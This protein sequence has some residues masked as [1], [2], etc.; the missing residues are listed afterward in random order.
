MKDDFIEKLP[1]IYGVYTGGFVVFIAL[2]AL[3]EYLGVNAQAIGILF[4]IFTVAVYAAIGVISR[5]KKVD[6]YYVAGREVP[7]VF[8]GMA[9]AADWMSGAIFIGLAGGLYFGGFAHLGF[10]IGWMGGYVLVNALMAPYLRKFGCYTLP[11]FVG[12]R[13]TGDFTRFLA[14]AIL[15]VVSFTYLTAQISATGAIASRMFQIPF[16]LAVWFGLVGI[17]FCSVLGGM[18]AVTWTQVAQYLVL[19]VAYLL[20]VIWISQS[21]GYGLLPH[22]S[23]GEAVQRVAELE[24]TLGLAGERTVTEDGLEALALAQNDPGAAG[25]MASWQFLTLAICMMAGTAS[26][27]HLLMR[28]FT[29][30]NVKAARQSVG[31]S[32]LFILVLFVSAPVLAT[33]AK[34]QLLDPEAATAVVGK[35]IDDVLSLG[36]VQTWSEFNFLRVEDLNG[37]GLV[38]AAEFFMHPDMVVLAAPEVAGLPYVVAGLIAAGGLAA[39]LSTADALL[40]SIANSASHDVYYK[41]TNPKADARARLWVARVALVVIGVVAA[42]FAKLQVGTALE[43]VAWAFCFACSGLFVPLLLGI[44]WKRANQQG[45][46]AGM[47]LGFAAGALYLYMVYDPPGEAVALMEPWWGIDSLRFGIVGMTV[48]FVGMVVISL[49][50]APPDE[51]IQRMVDETRLPA[52]RAILDRVE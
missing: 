37:D 12:V 13:Y 49:M 22:L 36:W 6:A 47:L 16:E 38:Q 32:A 4:V 46:V 20:P 34:L 28:Y 40:L 10:L 18:R 8:N 29:T 43:F 3:L 2:M 39:A 19:I 33:L 35:S 21:M 41:M 7:P 48:S 11:D 31:W 27:P 15:A 23:F 50:T 51:E 30:P 24:G 9:T 14:A 42:L 26:M 17:L 44:W 5:T 1:K 25:S 45:A 52:G